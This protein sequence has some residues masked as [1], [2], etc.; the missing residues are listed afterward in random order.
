MIDWQK[1]FESNN[2]DDYWPKNGRRSKR[3]KN[4]W[5]QTSCPVCGSSSDL[6]GIPEYGFSGNCYLCG[7]ISATKIVSGLLSVPYSKAQQLIH[8]HKVNGIDEVRINKISAAKKIKVRNKTLDLPPHTNLKKSGAQYLINR[9]FDPKNL[10]DNY[11]IVQGDK[12]D[13]MWKNRIIFPIY[14]EGL[15]IS[16]IGRDIIGD[17][18]CKYLKCKDVD[19][20]IPHKSIL[21][22]YDLCYEDFVIVVEGVADVV[23]WPPG[24]AVATFGV[25][26]S[27]E[28]L[29]LLAEKFS[30]VYV[31]FDGEPKAQVQGK[32]LANG[33][34]MRGVESYNLCLG[35]DRDSADLS[36]DEKTE[37]LNMIKGDY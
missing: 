3:T 33:L 24:I 34:S 23:S 29:N 8:E 9:G 18:K 16:Y 20:V 11:G 19:E 10:I 14:F 22:S 30:R 37:I 15:L 5:L 36:E 7:K 32:A 2:Y 28:Q 21:Y 1:L 4:G 6:L 13:F 31:L 17:N 27:Q 12:D 25:L 26:W 35:G